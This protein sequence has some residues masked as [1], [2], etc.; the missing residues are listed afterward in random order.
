MS[1]VDSNGLPLG[2]VLKAEYEISP[3][4]LSEMLAA[5]D[6]LLIMD[7]RTAGERDVAAILP[8]IHRALHE[9]EARVEEILEE[10]D[11]RQ[12]VAHSLSR[13]LH[14][15]GRAGHAAARRLAADPPRSPG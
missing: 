11:G 12:V 2:Y 14:L 15:T 4:K 6:E 13:A 9:I 5:K 3:R 1:G 10:A 8:S 7:V